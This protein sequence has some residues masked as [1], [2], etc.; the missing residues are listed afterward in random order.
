MNKAM[1]KYLAFSVSLIL[2]FSVV[3][4]VLA[5]PDT[6]RVPVTNDKAGVE[7]IIPK[8]AQ[9]VA[10]GVFSLGLA[11]DID[12]RMVEGY[13]IIDKKKENAKPGTVCG[14]GICEPGEKKSCTADCGGG[15]GDTGK[16]TCYALFAKGARWKATEPYIT[17][18]G[19]DLDFTETSLETWD[20]EVSFNIFGTRD[21]SRVVDGA[22]DESPDGKNEVEFSYLGAGGTIA[23]TIVWGIFSGPPPGRVLI[24]W[25]AVFNTYYPFGDYN[26]GDETTM[27]YRNI[28]VHEFGHALGLSHPDDSCTEETMYRFASLNETKKRTLEAGDIAGVNK[29]YS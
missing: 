8:H 18:P 3:G 11:Q 24:E 9:E 28:A 23:Y 19:I 13:L 12:G 10:D 22:D 20:S 17:G 4:M 1:K 21:A 27:D 7:L 2:I 6:T 5:R 29:L 14:N 25:D 16:S 15:N 26:P